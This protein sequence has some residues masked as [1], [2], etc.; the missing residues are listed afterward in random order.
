MGERVAPGGGPALTGRSVTSS[1]PGPTGGPGAGDAGL[2][3]SSSTGEV[4]GSS[5]PGRQSGAVGPPAAISNR[6]RDRSWPDRSALAA[7]VGEFVIEGGGAAFPGVGGL[8]DADASS[9][10]GLAMGG[11]AASVG[12]LGLS[13]HLRR[14][15]G[16]ILRSRGLLATGR[17]GQERHWTPPRAARAEPGKGEDLRE[18]AVGGIPSRARPFPLGRAPAARTG[19]GRRASRR[20]R[21]T[22]GRARSDRQTLTLSP[23]FNPGS[24]AW[25]AGEPGPPNS[26]ARTGPTDP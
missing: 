4:R 25:L 24:P 9:F 22:P 15:G 8:G 21:T 23:K 16:E 14:R 7:A 2:R 3:W 12:G 26:R 10:G 20:P 6:D 5:R 18:E 13:G 19:G 17:T 11:L 1:A